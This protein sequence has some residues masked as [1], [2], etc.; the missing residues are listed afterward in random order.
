MKKKFFLQIL[1]ACAIQP[2]AKANDQIESYD[3][4][5]KDI[6]TY[7]S[8]YELEI[9]NLTCKVKRASNPNHPKDVHVW[10]QHKYLPTNIQCYLVFFPD[11]GTFPLYRNKST[12]LFMYEDL[13]NVSESN[14]GQIF[15]LGHRQ[16]NKLTSD[17]KRELSLIMKK[18][19]GPLTFT[20]RTEI[21]LQVHRQA[22]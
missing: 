20:G 6:V 22:N 5:G 3:H 1:F 12:V 7:D 15:Q 14:K 17:L 11:E 8:P 16:T 9:E 21:N 18:N 13:N 19:C 4:A 10:C 2:L